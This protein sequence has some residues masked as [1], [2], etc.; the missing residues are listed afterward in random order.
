ML[1][2]FAFASMKK[3]ARDHAHTFMKKLGKTKMGFV[4]FLLLVWG[5]GCV[6][7][8]DDE[9]MECLYKSF[10][11]SDGCVAELA[12]VKSVCVSQVAVE[13]LYLAALLIE[14]TMEGRLGPT[15]QAGRD[16]LLLAIDR[17]KNFS[18]VDR[19]RDAMAECAKE[20]FP[21]PGSA[22]KSFSEDQSFQISSDS[23][24]PEFRTDY[25]IAVVSIAS[26]GLQAFVGPGLASAGFDVTA[27]E[28]IEHDKTAVLPGSIA[29][30]SILIPRTSSW[31]FQIEVLADAL[32]LLPGLTRVFPADDQAL[33]ALFALRDEWNISASLRNAIDLS[34]P[35]SRLLP[36]KWEWSLLARSVVASG[37]FR[38]IRVP[39]AVLV[40]KNDSETT[41]KDFERLGGE[42]MVKLENSFGGAFVR[43]ASCL[44]EVE[45]AVTD[46]T[47]DDLQKVSGRG[48]KAARV[49][50]QEHVGGDTNPLP[51]IVVAFAAD[52]GK[53]I[54][55]YVAR[56]EESWSGA[57]AVLKTMRSHVIEAF[58][59]EF[60]KATNI[61][62]FAEIDFLMDSHNTFW[63]ID[64]NPRLIAM[65]CFVS[66]IILE[67]AEFDLCS[68]YF[69]HAAKMQPTKH[70]PWDVKSGVVFI[71][72][73]QVIRKSC[74][75]P[76]LAPFRWNLPFFDPAVVQGIIAMGNSKCEKEETE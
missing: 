65:T 61:T 20:F 42:V 44:D 55:G 49:I 56:V 30:H 35:Q 8:C 9:D 52:K 40:H 62:G 38:K 4:L 22:C 53:L 70:K 7:P 28:A 27:I 73:I 69:Q 37:N 29:T 13:Q 41:L 31:T 19:L 17:N 26:W 58:V 18:V 66:K 57:S 10:K 48:G 59:T 60:A 21:T 43:K 6:L 2:I 74:N 54:S 5:S 33:T 1:N 75:S 25:P 24:Q 71:H 50:M 47:S 63:M 36:S 45:T 72:P 14:G 23:R 46:L 64:L 76:H 15:T 16:A 11:G 32:A 68:E 51:L 39:D 12:L 34:I 3:A 67:D